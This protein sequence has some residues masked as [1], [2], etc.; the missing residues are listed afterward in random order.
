MFVDVFFGSEK[1]G[2]SGLN[3]VDLLTLEADL[4][5]LLAVRL[6]NAGDVK[7]LFD[8]LKKNAYHYLLLGFRL[9]TLQ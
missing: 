3:W 9:Q 7:N 4:D 5:K 8:A 6:K 1:A 2:R